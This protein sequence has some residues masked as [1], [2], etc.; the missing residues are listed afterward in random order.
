MILKG[1]LS[2]ISNECLK[3]LIRSLYPTELELQRLSTLH[4]MQKAISARRQS[5]LMAI[6]S[7]ALDQEHMVNHHVDFWDPLFHSYL[8]SDILPCQFQLLQQPR[9]L[10]PLSLTK[11]TALFPLSCTPKKVSFSRKL[12]TVMGQL[13]S[14]PQVFSFCQ[15]SQLCA[16]YYPMPEKICLIILSSLIFFFSRRTSHVPITFSRLEASL[17]CTLI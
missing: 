7:P 4:D 1:C 2:G 13:W 11:T 17:W 10:L 12:R 6:F 5:L 9:P 14:T 15:R 3:C 8:F 16:A